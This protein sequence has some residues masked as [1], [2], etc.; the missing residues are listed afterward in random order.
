MALWTGKSCMNVKHYHQHVSPSILDG[1]QA[2]QEK[3]GITLT[4]LVPSYTVFSGH[5]NHP[6]E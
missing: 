2:L 3:P 5:C 4:F 1:L 6:N